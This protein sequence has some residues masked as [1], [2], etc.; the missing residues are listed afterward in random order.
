MQGT[1]R[2]KVLGGRSGG[3]FTWQSSPLVRTSPFMYCL[4]RVGEM[5]KLLPMQRVSVLPSTRLISTEPFKMTYHRS[6]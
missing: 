1:W 3:V 6:S 5:P 4:S 2:Q